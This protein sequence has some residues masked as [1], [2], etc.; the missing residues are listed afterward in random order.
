[1]TRTKL[2][3]DVGLDFTYLLSTLLQPDPTSTSSHSHPIF[4]LSGTAETPAPGYHID[5]SPYVPYIPDTPAPI[6]EPPVMGNT[7]PL[8]VKSPRKARASETTSTA[9]EVGEVEEGSRPASA[10][11][12]GRRSGSASPVP[13]P[14]SMRREASGS[15][16]PTGQ[17][18]EEGDGDSLR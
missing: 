7:Q 8:F 17:R 11:H 12:P 5:S 3:R 13:P 15:R 10:D 4:D 2:L 18:A 1:M 9:R 14:R 6:P 16:T